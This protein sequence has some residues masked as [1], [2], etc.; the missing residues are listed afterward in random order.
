MA[1]TAGLTNTK[2]SLDR[3][4]ELEKAGAPAESVRG[5]TVRLNLLLP[6]QSAARLERLKEL[7][8]ASS[9]TEVIR[10]AIRVYEAIIQE[11]EKGNKVQF[12]DKD[13]RPLGV[14]VF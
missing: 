10:N 6:Q 1:I 4:I 9:Y 3:G 13:N 11:Y 2:E 8:E 12:V 14:S 7:T 5:K